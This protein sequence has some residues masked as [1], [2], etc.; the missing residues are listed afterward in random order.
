M[1]SS[2]V[3]SYYEALQFL[4]WEP[5]HIGRKKHGGAEFDTSE[6]VKKHLRRMEVTLNHN[7]NQFFLLAPASLRND[8]FRQL[9]DCSFHRPFIMY[10]GSVDDE[11]KLINAMQPDFLFASDTEV[12]SLEMKVGAK[13]SVS[14]VLKYA[15]LGLAVEMQVGAPRKHYLAVLGAGEFSNQWQEQFSSV[16][17]LRHA[18]TNADLPSFLSK[19]PV[20]FR[21][22]QRRF[23]EIVASLDLAFVNYSGLAA[24][25]R[26]VA[27]P[28]SDTTLGAE[29]Y[30][31]LVSGLLGEFKTRQLAA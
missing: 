15:L 1:E 16:A 6:K 2:W 9:F 31:K 5:Q 26:G 27:P 10:G 19:R 7:I 28:D 30:R 22:H 11:L 21:E 17:E 18:I 20:R 13:S 3:E 8:L 29:V 23:N 12:V 25:L 24:F 4:Y 14:Q